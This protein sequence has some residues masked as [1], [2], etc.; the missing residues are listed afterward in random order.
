MRAMIVAVAVAL[1]VAGSAGAQGTTPAEVELQSAIRTET[2]KGD[3]GAAIAEYEAIV[4]R[5]GTTDRAVAAAALVR[6]AGCHQKMGDAKAREIYERVVRE[7]ADQPA[8]AEARERLG[9]GGAGRAAAMEYRRLWAGKEAGR[10]LS[11]TD[12]STG[13]LAVRDLTTGSVRR[14]TNTGGWTASDAWAEGSAI[15][16]DGRSVAYVW[17]VESGNAELRLVGTAPG[18]AERPR[19]LMSRGER[20][21]LTPHAWSPD[22]KTLAVSILEDSRQELVLVTVADGTVRTLRA[23]DP[24]GVAGV[25]FSPDGA[26]VAY[27]AGVGPANGD[28]SD[29]YVRAV[30]GGAEVAVARGSGRD[31]VMGWS[32]DGGS[33]LFASDRGGTNALWGQVMKAG[34]PVGVPRLLKAD[35]GERSLGTSAS[36]DL[37]VSVQVGERNVYVGEFDLAAARLVG[38]AMPAA[39]RHVGVNQWPDWSAD[40]QY[41]AYVSARTMQGRR[42]ILSIRALATGETRELSPALTQFFAPRWAPDGRSLAV[43]GSDLRG[44]SGIF[45]VG[46]ARGEVAPLVEATAERNPTWPEWSR[47]GTKLYYLCFERTASGSAQVI[48]E[49]T[50]ASGAERELLRGPSFLGIPSLS[51]DGTLLGLGQL[52]TETREYVLLLLPVGGGEP[53]EVL[54]SPTKLSPRPSWTPDGRLIVTRDGDRRELLLVPTSGGQPRVVDIPNYSFGGIHFHPDGRRVAYVGGTASSEVWVFE[55]LDAALAGRR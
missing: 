15:S 44:R 29:V 43:Q 40:G 26:F 30:A 8:A 34:Q 20:A 4:R 47:D 21:W 42:P 32:R 49:R 18:L 38:E 5:H 13:D 52:R 25:A 24:R 28:D 2:V 14:L 12:W 35:I 50:L 48:V 39:E 6:M 55:G 45:R 22:G 37:F 23:V 7:Y 46:V 17:Y 16:P 53:R 36:G 3:L 1:A 10:W 9:T 31:V 51:P 41:L 33:L 19:T 27:D 54:R 11:F